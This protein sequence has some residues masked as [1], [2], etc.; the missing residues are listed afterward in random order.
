MAAY[1]ALRGL[2]QVMMD[3]LLEPRMLHDAMAFFEE[4]CRR[5][6]QQYVDLNLLDLNNDNTYH[7]S[8]GRGWTDELPAEGFDPAHVRPR[9]LWASAE[10]QE[11]AQVSP[12]MHEEF[13]LQ[14]ER[15]LLA[16]FGLNGYGCCEDLTRKLDDVLRIPRI[17]R[18]S[19]SPWADA[20]RCA[21]KLGNRYIFSWKPKPQMVAGEYDPDRIRAYLRRALEAT[22]GCVFEMVLKDTHTCD[23]HPERFE[24]WSRIAREEIE[25]L[26]E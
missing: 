5:L 3:M 25:R 13:I 1:T 16:P 21:E 14:Y 17:R 22:R 26:G 12:A 24:V 18:I 4:G 8:G 15:R 2:E 6:V 20:E 10:A 7:S 11:M 9:D 23:G 19:I